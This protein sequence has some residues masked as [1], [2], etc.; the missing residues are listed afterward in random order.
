MS[1]AWRR[2]SLRVWAAAGAFW[3]SA[4]QFP[5]YNL[6]RDAP[7]GGSGTT[8]QAGSTSGGDTQHVDGGT[9]GAGTSSG[10]AGATNIAGTA[11][12]TAGVAGTSPGTAG[13]PMA[14]TDAGGTLGD[15]GSAGAASDPKL[16]LDDDFDSGNAEQ[17]F[18][19][20]GSPWSVALDAQRASQGYQLTPVFTDFYAS[21]A[22]DGPWTD[23]IIDADVKVLAF[24]GTGTGDVVSL[25]GRFANI[26]NYY[27]AV[28][29]PDGR[30]AIRAR[31]A[32]SPPSSIKT[33]AALG[34]TAGT[35]Y[36]LR[37]ELVGS[38]LRLSIDGQLRAEVEDTSLTKGTVALGGDNSAAIF[39]NVRV[40][41][42]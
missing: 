12:A 6:G 15:G 41:L 34:M 2:R 24:G 28:L 9:S 23:Q 37:F 36:H 42:P 11:G 21:A 31:V 33:S 30:A 5:N 19:V 14:G 16:L 4:C 26:D 27:A 10:G 29:R 38:A 39:D 40:T 35:W 25:L 17:W 1:L 32:G 20:A 18:E 8:P 7:S 3:A 22:K 13:Q